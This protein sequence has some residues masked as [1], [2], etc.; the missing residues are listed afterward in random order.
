VIIFVSGKKSSNGKALFS[1]C[2][3]TNE[4][5]YFI[6]NPQE[7]EPAWFQGATTV[8]IAGATSTPMWLME[9][10]SQSIQQIER[11]TPVSA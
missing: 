10:V 7:L 11:S 2:K 8:G 1:V 3:S 9:E 4:Q 6:S 5:T